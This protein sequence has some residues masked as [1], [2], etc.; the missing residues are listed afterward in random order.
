MNE[1]PEEKAPDAK[2]SE[3]PRDARDTRKRL[4][5]AR[6]LNARLGRTKSAPERHALESASG[7][8][9]SLLVEISPEYV[10]GNLKEK[11]GECS[12]ILTS[13]GKLADSLA[14]LDN[15]MLA[16]MAISMQSSRSPTLA[17]LHEAGAQMDLFLPGSL[18]PEHCPPP[19]P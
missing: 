15:R 7:W 2:P 12:K 3:P 13:A 10:R 14:R 19:E 9:Y 6:R 18:G 8:L 4:L 16:G 11:A 17:G 5:E 1:A